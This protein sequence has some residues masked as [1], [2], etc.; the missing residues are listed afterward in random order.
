MNK[1]HWREM[2]LACAVGPQI[3]T[4]KEGISG[5]LQT[6]CAKMN[7]DHW[8]EMSLAHAQQD[9]RMKHKKR[10]HYRAFAD[11]MRK[12]EQRRLARNEPGACAVRPQNET[13]KGRHFR[14]F[15]DT[16]KN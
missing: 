14:A 15:A 5:H 11:S 4:K 6:V 9:H 8:R 1:D 2:S 12:N 10:R 7:K 3:K 13:Q 16:R